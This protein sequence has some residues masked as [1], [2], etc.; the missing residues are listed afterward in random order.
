MQTDLAS[1]GAPPASQ[2]EQITSALSPSAAAAQPSTQSDAVAPVL[3]VAAAVVTAA[4]NCLL[5]LVVNVND[6]MDSIIAY[7]PFQSNHDVT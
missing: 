3:A 1:A 5:A 6:G 4:L 7:N 2:D